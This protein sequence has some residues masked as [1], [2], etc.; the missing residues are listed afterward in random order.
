MPRLAASAANA[1]KLDPV[2]TKAA[3][4][5]AAANALASG[6][7]MAKARGVE[8]MKPP[9]SQARQLVNDAKAKWSGLGAQ[10]SSSKNVFAKSK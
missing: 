9:S 4:K 2:P 1:R 8:L 3:S 5:V 6:W 10:N 7:A